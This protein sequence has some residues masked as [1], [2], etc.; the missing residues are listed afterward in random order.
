MD[1]IYIYLLASVIIQLIDIIIFLYYS[2]TLN[3]LIFI[4][5]VLLLLS[6]RQFKINNNIYKQQNTK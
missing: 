1:K 2:Q 5:I 6:W 4:S 3:L